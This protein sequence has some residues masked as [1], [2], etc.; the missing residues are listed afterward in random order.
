MNV[1]FLNNAEVAPFSNGIQRVTDLVAQGLMH[2]HN[3]RCYSA[4]FHEN[5]VLPKSEFCGKLLLIRGQETEQIFRFIS[6]NK[7]EVVICQEISLDR[8]VFRAIRVAV[9]KV[10]NC[11]LIY[12]YH[13]SPD[14]V[15]VRPN[16]SIKFY[17]LIHKIDRK[18]SLKQLFVSMVPSFLYSFMVKKQTKRKNIFINAVFDKVVLL[19]ESHI[20][21]YCFLS[22][23]SS[24]KHQTK[25]VAIPNP[26]TFPEH[27]DMNDWP[28]KKKEVIIVS[29]LSDRSKRI[30][31]GLRI[32]KKVK[33]DH[34]SSGWKLTIVGTGEDEQYYKDLSEKLNLKDVSFEG[35]Q[36]PLKYYERASVCMITS[37]YEGF[38]MNMLESLQMGV[39]PVVF[40]SY[41]ALHDMLEDG[42]NGIIVPNND[43]NK[44]VN[45][46]LGLFQDERK[47]KKMAVEGLKSADKFSIENITD[48][49]ISLFKSM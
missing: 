49:W 12:C 42:K 1:L 34:L 38:S 22:D 43:L 31:L 40:D 33:M 3:V 24:V 6:E 28:E 21:P 26:Q 48:Q 44:Y 4:F 30:A 2:I 27:F 15:F 5:D 35:R 23:I 7:I 17:N 8:E 25:V 16:F 39:V 11:K 46:L 47:R 9:D 41:S 10:E 20:A 36:D 37:S 13:S 18:R 45:E 14:N 32:W 19:S 29:R